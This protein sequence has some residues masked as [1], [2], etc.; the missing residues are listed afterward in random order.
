MFSLY[1][2]ELGINISSISFWLFGIG[3]FYLIVLVGEHFRDNLCYFL[4]TSKFGIKNIFIS[5]FIFLSPFFHLNAVAILHTLGIDEI[6]LPYLEIGV[7]IFELIFVIAVGYYYLVVI[8][9][10]GLVM[11]LIFYFLATVANAFIGELGILISI[12]IIVY[13]YRDVIIK[14][15]TFP[16]ELLSCFIK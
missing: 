9:L 4:N 5:I 10:G 2:T 11:L 14:I 8:L 1:P 6:K 13:L 16:K 15:I 7:I 12:A 3:F